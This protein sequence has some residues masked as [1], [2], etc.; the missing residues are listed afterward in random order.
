MYLATLLKNEVILKAAKKVWELGERGTDLAKYLVKTHKWKGI[1]IN[2]DSKHPVDSNSE[3]T[4]TSHLASKTCKYYKIP[5]E[6]KVHNYTITPKSHPS[7]QKLNK[8]APV[9]TLNPLGITSLGLVKFGFGVSKG[10]E[11]TWV[12]SKGNVYE[13]HWD[14]IGT[15]LHEKTPLR[16]FPWLSGAIVVPPDQALLLASSARMKCRE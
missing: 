13:V 16:M 15:E 12:F 3:H 10:G 11:H 5:L 9:T 1:Y 8:T 6:Y 14:K 7:F 4:Y 2:P